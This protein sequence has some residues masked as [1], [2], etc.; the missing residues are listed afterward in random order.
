MCDNPVTRFAPYYLSELLQLYSPRRCLCSS[1]NTKML[2]L[3][4]FKCVGFVVSPYLVLTS[5]TT[6]PKTLGTL[7]LSI[8]SRINSK[9]FLFFEYFY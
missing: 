5:E 1:T 8:P 4:R 6:A 9:H 3:Q 7:L 2:E